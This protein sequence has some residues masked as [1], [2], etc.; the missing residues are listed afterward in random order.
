MEQV[1]KLFGGHAAG[2]FDVADI[3]RRVLIGAGVP[4]LAFALFLALQNLAARR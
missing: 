4:L 2:R 1:L 3:V